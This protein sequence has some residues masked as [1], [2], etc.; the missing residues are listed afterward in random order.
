MKE[1]AGVF[2][3]V[4]LGGLVSMVLSHFGL[5]DASLFWG[6]FALLCGA[7]WMAAKETVGEE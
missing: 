4:E 1:N 5:G 2:I 6:G 3:L 7:A